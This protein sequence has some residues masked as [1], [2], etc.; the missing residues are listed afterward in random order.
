[1]QDEVFNF[2]SVTPRNQDLDSRA[3][4]LVTGSSRKI[5]VRLQRVTTSQA[6]QTEP[7][8]H[9]PG[10]GDS[11]SHTFPKMKSKFHGKSGKN[12]GFAKWENEKPTIQAPMDMAVAT[13]ARE[14]DQNIIETLLERQEMEVISRIALTNPK[15]VLSFKV[16]P[17][18]AFFFTYSGPS[19]STG[20]PFRTPH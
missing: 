8:W 7:L 17:S 20:D 18:Y 15:Q 13:A 5:S 6:T 9:D 11:G 16:L 14:L 2:P 3:I 12:K 19:V 10:W 4:M 1:M